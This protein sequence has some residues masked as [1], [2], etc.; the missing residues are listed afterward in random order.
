MFLT[1]P[2]MVIKVDPLEKTIDMRWE[3]MLLVGFGSFV[4]SIA[5]RIFFE[6]RRK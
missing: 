6:R 5:S 4:L 3:N 1:F 2:I